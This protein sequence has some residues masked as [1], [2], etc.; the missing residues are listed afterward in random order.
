MTNGKE[1]YDNQGPAGTEIQYQ[2]GEQ[3]QS[4]RKAQRVHEKVRNVQGL[5]QKA[6]Q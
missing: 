3:M 6:C 1:V 4:M 5:L 2:A